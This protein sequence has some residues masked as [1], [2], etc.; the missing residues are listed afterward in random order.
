[1]TEQ[2]RTD[3]SSQDRTAET[4]PSG[5]DAGGHEPAPPSEDPA[6]DE[7]RDMIQDAFD[8]LEATHASDAIWAEADRHAEEAPAPG[9]TPVEMTGDAP[10]PESTG[11][12]SEK[13]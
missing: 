2:R 7:A 9:T 6:A 13:P 5:L 12:P 8:G 1:M 4:R 11:G 3:E 10:T